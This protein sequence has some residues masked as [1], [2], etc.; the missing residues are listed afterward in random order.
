MQTLAEI[1]R[2]LAARG[3][4][5]RHRFGQNFLHDPRLVQRL[6]QAA[7]IVPG[8]VILEVGPGTGTLTEALLDAGA[9][10]IASEIDRDLCG[11]I[12][13]RMVERLGDAAPDR[14]TLVAG[15]CLAAGRAL[16]PAIVEAIRGR[17]FRLVANLPY[18]IASPLIATLVLH[19]ASC[20]GLFVTVQ[21]E[22]ADRLTAAPGSRAAGTLGILVQTFADVRRLCTLPPGAFWPPP[23]V[24]SAMVAIRPDR[25]AAGVDDPESYARFVAGLFSQRRKTLGRI[26]RDRTPGPAPGGAE[27]HGEGAGPPWPPGIRP[28]Q[29]PEELSP[30][31]FV[32]LWRTMRA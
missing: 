9:V 22:V 21:R 17:A 10:V 18:A 24:E 28:G 26:L 13:D 27:T 30:Q 4:S 2:L 5:P 14:F 31:A 8:E 6:V 19:H 23:K 15:D 20:H 25:A 32:A 12:E 11:L 29:R 16:A 1:R 7:E 3:L